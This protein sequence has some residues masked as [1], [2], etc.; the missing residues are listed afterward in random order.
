[1]AA[2]R[3]A[4][5]AG[6]A[7]FAAIFAL[8]FVLGTIRILWLAP[9]L[10]ATAAVALELPLMLVASWFAAKPL[11]ARF[12]LAGVPA[13]GAMGM[14]G[15]LFLLAAEAVLAIVAFDATAAGWLAGLLKM[16]GILGLA[17]QIGFALMPLLVRRRA[18]AL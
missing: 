11:V 9:W 16:P 7:Y 14:T 15:F 8:G 6:L 10:G 13:R 18:H 4:I 1:M 3:S 17:G 2:M 12:A 5:L